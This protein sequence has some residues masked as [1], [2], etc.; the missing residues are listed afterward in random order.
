MGSLAKRAAAAFQERG[1]EA[2][3]DTLSAEPRQISKTTHRS[4]GPGY[5]EPSGDHGQTSVPT[6]DAVMKGY[7]VY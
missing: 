7:K 5:Q 1:E 4:T 3:W 2:Y 6:V